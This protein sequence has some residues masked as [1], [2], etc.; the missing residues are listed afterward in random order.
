MKNILKY[1]IPFSV[2]IRN[3][4]NSPLFPSIFFA[5]VCLITFWSSL[6]NGFKLDDFTHFDQKLYLSQLSFRTLFMQSAT[7]HYNPLDPLFNNWLFSIWTENVVAFRM[8]N[9]TLFYFNVLCLFQI[10]LMVTQARW[11]SLWTALIFAIHPINAEIVNQIAFNTVLLSALLAQLSFIFFDRYLTSQRIGNILI[12]GLCALIAFLMLEITWIL[13]WYFFCWAYLSKQKSLRLAIVT[14]LPFGVVVAFLFVVWRCISQSSA[15]TTGILEKFH[16]L[17]LSPLTFIGSLAKLL[18]WYLTKLFI[19]INHIWIYSIAPLS[20][21]Q[22][23]ASLMV[24]S[25]LTVMYVILDRVV[26]LRS[27]SFAGIWFVSGFIFLLPGSLAHPEAGLVIEPYWFYISSMGFFILMAIAINMIKKYIPGK[28]FVALFVFVCVTLFY[29]VQRINRI[30]RSEKSYC[31]YWLNIGM[32]S[33]PLNALG[34][35]AYKN[36]EYEKALKYYRYYLNRYAFSPYSYYRPET[37]YTKIALIYLGMED[38]E[39]AKNMVVQALAHNNNSVEANIAQGL[40]DSKEKNYA[41]AEKDFLRVLE[42]DPT[43]TVSQF[44]LVDIYR[45]TSRPDQVIQ[46]LKALT[47]QNLTDIER[48]SVYAKLAVFQFRYESLEA[49]MDTVSQL[50]ERDSSVDSF[51]AVAKDFESFHFFEPAGIILQ[52]GI[53]LYPKYSKFYLFLGEVLEKQ[54][55]TAD[56][57]EIWQQGQELFPLDI[58]FIER[59]SQTKT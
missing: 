18:L 51:L 30:A 46:V 57:L 32:N 59:I 15:L 6:H 37:V 45:A 49:S 43:N 25:I 24:L 41:L 9:I 20:L 4:V 42:I 23:K 36:K 39:N 50:L 53:K 38:L 8:L 21:D 54:G 17:M 1:R 40:I 52:Q 44:N 55:R 5:L 12:T 13:P 28:L 27:F 47:H 3:A 19:P 31:E 14:A 22:A 33:V 48:R 34:H 10:V 11:V 7:N 16:Y 35:L 2:L 58:Q 29:G 56:A 26:R